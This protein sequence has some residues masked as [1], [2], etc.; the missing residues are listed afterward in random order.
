MRAR[1]IWFERFLLMTLLLGVALA[2]SAAQG[3]RSSRWRPAGARGRGFNP[4]ALQL[5]LSRV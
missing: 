4:F 1:P 2:P 5:N 3:G